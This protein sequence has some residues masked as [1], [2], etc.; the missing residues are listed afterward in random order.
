MHRTR[1]FLI[2]IGFVAIT[3]TVVLGADPTPDA[4]DAGLSTAAQHAGF[5]VPVANGFVEQGDEATDEDLDEN[6][7]EDEDL[8]ENETE[9]E[10]LDENETEDLEEPAEHPDNHGA[11]VSAAAQDVTL[12]LEGNHGHYVSSIARDNHGQAQA[13]AHA[14]AGGGED[15][16][17]E[18]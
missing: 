15:D 18:E 3:A 14:N 6:E 7:T 8:D 2:A 9:D 4:A 16:D 11:D 5:T 1:S 12:E 17:S 10:D 13:A